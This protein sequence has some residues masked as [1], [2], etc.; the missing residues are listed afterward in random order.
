MLLEGFRRHSHWLD[1]LV[2]LKDF[3]DG[4]LEIIILNNI[5]LLTYGIIIN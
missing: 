5:I 3:K 2:P 1:G 4:T